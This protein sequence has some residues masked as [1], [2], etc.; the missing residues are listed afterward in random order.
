M[1]VRADQRMGRPQVSDPVR[2]RRNRR[3]STPSADIRSA[4]EFIE[5]RDKITDAIY[6][7]QD[8]ASSPAA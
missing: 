7:T 4:E 5:L 2:S 1:A 3:S 6:S 8:D